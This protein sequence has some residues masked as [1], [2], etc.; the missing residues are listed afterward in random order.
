MN[1]RTLKIALAASLALNVFG[2]AAG[3]TAYLNRSAAE[4]RVEQ[5]RSERVRVP[6]MQAIDSL[7]ESR[8]ETVPA[9]LRE[10]ALAARPDF[11]EARRARREAIA[12]VEAET[13]D[14]AAVSALLEQSRASELRGRARLEAG[15]VRVLSDLTPEERA[16]MSV[17]LMRH[18]GKHRDRPQAPSSDREATPE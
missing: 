4:E 15:A 14:A 8:R 13:F 18:G 11:Q 9:T 17:L 1:Q 5:G 7:E 2:A 16:R 6:A 3:V 12:R 10:S